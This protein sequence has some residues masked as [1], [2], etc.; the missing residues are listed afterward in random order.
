MQ[1]EWNGDGGTVIESG[2]LEELVAVTTKPVRCGF[3]VRT[4]AGNGL[5]RYEAVAV[6]GF[7]GAGRMETYWPPT[8]GDLISLRD[9]R[10]EIAG[11]PV[12]RVIERAWHHSGYG[13][14]GRPVAWTRM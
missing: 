14:S 7:G 12:Y 3:Y 10:K 2:R 9:Q 1:W 4:P 6:P 8:V 11:G 13:L 5:Y